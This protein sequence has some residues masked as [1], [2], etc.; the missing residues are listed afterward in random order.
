M[1]L[2]IF[3]THKNKTKHIEDLIKNE[4]F[5]YDLVFDDEHPDVII[6]IGGDGTFLR[7][8]QS[9]IDRL[10]DVVFIGINKGTLGYFYDADENDIEDLFLRLISSSLVEHHIPLLMG[11]ASN[12]FGEVE[13]FAVNEVVVNC[14]GGAIC[15]EVFINNNYFEKYVGSGLLISSS[16]GSTGLN[17]SY[18]GPVIKNYLRCNCLTPIAPISN[19]VY[20]SFVSPFVL[21]SDDVISI[22]GG[23]NNATICFDNV[24]ID[25]KFDTLDIIPAKAYVRVLYRQDRDELYPIRKSFL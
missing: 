20:N 6:Y 1:K 16:Y 15:T 23:I 14:V 3:S 25:D 8:V 12:N 21:S 10:D 4:A 5:K 17:K 13:F 22:R 24:V 18:N 2:S 9:N 7:E 11:K 19:A